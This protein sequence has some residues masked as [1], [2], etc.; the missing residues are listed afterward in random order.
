MRNGLF[1]HGHDRDSQRSVSKWTSCAH[2]C[3]REEVRDRHP[4]VVEFIIQMFATNSSFAAFY[5]GNSNA[6]AYVR[7]CSTGAHNA[8]ARQHNTAARAYS[9]IHAT[10]ATA[11]AVQGPGGRTGNNT[12]LEWTTK[13][14][15]TTACLIL[16]RTHLAAWKNPGS[17]LSATQLPLSCR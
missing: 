1:I 17:S 8:D 12:T 6:R 13:A 11:E 7:Y 3:R 15:Y 2:G 10:V 9:T 4:Q 16:L 14:D 5:T